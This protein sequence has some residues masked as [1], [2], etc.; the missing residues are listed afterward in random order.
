MGDDQSRLVPRVRP[1]FLSVFGTAEHFSFGFR[2]SVYCS[3]ALR[4]D[5]QVLSSA[6]TLQP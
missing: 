2:I 5:P 3:G 6:D 1:E 4:R